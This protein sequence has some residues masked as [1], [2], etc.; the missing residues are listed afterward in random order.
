MN[1]ITNTVIVSV[2]VKITLALEV[3]TYPLLVQLLQKLS[4]GCVR[5]MPKVAFKSIAIRKGGNDDM[6]KSHRVLGEVL[7]YLGTL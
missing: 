2:V 3:D 7:A 5:Q 1:L 4:D 6:R